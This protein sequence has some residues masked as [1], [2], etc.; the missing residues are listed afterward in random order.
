MDG[1][2]IEE[3]CG[4]WVCNLCGCIVYPF[5]IENGSYNYCPN[6]GDSKNE[7]DF[8]YADT[9]SWADASQLG[10]EVENGES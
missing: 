1:K 9:D 6:C 4:S 7:S 10:E 5:E 3:D 2:W 8:M